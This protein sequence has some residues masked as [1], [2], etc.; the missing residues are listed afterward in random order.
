MTKM[1]KYENYKETVFELNCLI[2]YSVLFLLYEI[3]F[4]FMLI[5]TK[6]RQ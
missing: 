4:L 2:G 1:E 5:A 3:E 6:L